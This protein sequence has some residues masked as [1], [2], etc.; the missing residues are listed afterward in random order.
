MSRRGRNARVSLVWLS[1][2]LTIAVVLSGC[3]SAGLTTPSQ[4]EAPDLS[5]LPY[6]IG[7]GDQLQ[8]MVWRNQE[9]SVSVPVRPDGFISVPLVGDIKALDMTP[10]GLARQIEESIKSYIRTPQVTVIVTN[11]ASSE[12]LHRVRITGAIRAPASLPYRKGMTVMDV[13]LGAGGVTEFGRG[14]SARLYRNFQETQEVYAVQIEDILQKGDLSTN[15]ELFPGDVITVP[16]R[17]F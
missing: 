12:Y 6:K 13:V 4:M 7:A 9:L 16:E 14:N 2:L 1:W 3:Q 5:S 17:L 8:V 11:P 10:E 15:Y